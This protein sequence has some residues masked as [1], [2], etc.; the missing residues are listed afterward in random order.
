MSSIAALVASTSGVGGIVGSGVEVE[1]GDALPAAVTLCKS[2]RAALMG[3]A[4]PMPVTGRPVSVL[5][6]LAVITPMTLP[7]ASSRGPPLLPGFSDASA[8]R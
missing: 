1:F 3:M 8:C 4:K 5:S 6:T 2:C 7:L